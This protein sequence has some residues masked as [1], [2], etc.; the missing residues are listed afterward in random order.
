MTAC[1][2]I[3]R[4]HRK[5]C[6]GDLD[7]EIILHDRAIKPP[8]FNVVDFDENFTP[9]NTVWSSVNTVAGKTIFDGVSQDYSVTHEFVIRYDASVT[10]ET[11]IEFEGRYFKIVPNGVQDWEERHE[12][13]SLLCTE[14]GLTTNNAAKV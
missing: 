14:R 8:G 3:K 11:W 1:V 5:P 9:S 12:W 2:T 7:R 4:K 13:L 10:V 6:I